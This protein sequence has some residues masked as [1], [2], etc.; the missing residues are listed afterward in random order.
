MNRRLATLSIAVATALAACDGVTEPREE[1]LDLFAVEVVDASSLERSGLP[2]HLAPGADIPGFAGAYFD[3]GCNL[4][5]LLVDLAYADRAKAAF[6]PLFRQRVASAR[7]CPPSATIRIQRAQYSFAQLMEWLGAA[8]PLVRIE[9]VSGLYI[10][11]PQNRVV[12]R[13]TAREAARA[14][15]AALARLGLPL[16]AFVFEPSPPPPPPRR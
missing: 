14:V 4:I 15:Q 7:H 16:E 8:R 6:R 12:V 5:I 9:G 11:V 10:H 2:A 3:R 13:V 1:E